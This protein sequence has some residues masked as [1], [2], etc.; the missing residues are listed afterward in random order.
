MAKSGH[1]HNDFR[2]VRGP[3][4]LVSGVAGGF[5]ALIYHLNVPD[6]AVCGRGRGLVW[7]TTAGLA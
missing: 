6:S 2:T 3:K 5:Q 4:W 1:S 7:P